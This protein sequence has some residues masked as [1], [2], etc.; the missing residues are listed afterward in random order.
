MVMIFQSEKARRFLLQNGVVFTF[1]VHRRLMTGEDWITDKRG[2][3]K[4]G[5]VQVEEEGVFDPS[6]LSI[7]VAYSGFN[8][9]EEWH[10][11]IKQILN[12]H[13]LPSEGWLYKVSLEE[14]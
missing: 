4:I 6:D 9:L 14:K 7:Y 11:E 8:S 2:G 1:R 10:E 5:D 12:G 13:R 3:R